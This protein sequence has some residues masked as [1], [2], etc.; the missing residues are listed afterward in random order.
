[1][2]DCCIYVAAPWKRREA[3]REVADY[4]TARG[5]TIIS[6]W[7]R[8]HGDSTN[9]AE[10]QHEALNDLEDLRRCDAILLLNLERSGGKE[11]EFGMAYVLGLK[12]IVVG[13]PEGNVFY[14]LPGVIVVDTIE[15]AI[16]YLK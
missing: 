14:H 1:M 2:K 10:L 9:H 15:Q 11:C 12:T 3:A 5:F 6:R 16:P 8:E 7:L 13:K 4:L